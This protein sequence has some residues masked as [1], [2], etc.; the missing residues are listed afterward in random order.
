MYILIAVVSACAYALQGTLMASIYRKMDVLSAVGFRGLAL[1]CTTLPL[2]LF[3][4]KEDFCVVPSIMGSICLCSCFGAFGNWF[5]A[6]TYKRLPCGV[7]SA[8]INSFRTITAVMFAVVLLGE[9]VNQTQYLFIFSLLAFVGILSIT[10]NASSEENFPR[11]AV[12]SGI[13]FSVICGVAIGSS[14]SLVGATAKAVHPLLMV[15]LWELTIGFFAMTLI[16]ARYKITGVKLDKV[17]LLTFKKIMLFSSPT[18]IGTFGFVYA[19]QLGSLAI[20]SAVLSLSAI[21]AAIYGL[22]FYRE[23]LNRKQYALIAL[24]CLAI[25]GLNICDMF[26]QA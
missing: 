8:L 22:F 7:A 17:S 21:F 6:H 19:T 4:P 16:F 10:R 20:V 15:F 11:G 25:A 13:A 12:F 2:L 14:M 3:V 26:L 5:L 24:C 18:I 23:K 9:I 1:G